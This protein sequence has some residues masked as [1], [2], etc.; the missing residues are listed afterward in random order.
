VRTFTF[1]DDAGLGIYGG[2]RQLAD[3]GPRIPSH[4]ECVR[5]AF[6]PG[7][8]VRL[9]TRPALEPHRC[10]PGPGS[11][12]Y[13]DVAEGEYAS[14]GFAAGPDL[15]YG[16]WE[17]TMAASSAAVVRVCPMLWPKAGE[18]WPPEFN[19]IEMGGDKD[20]AGRQIGNV[21]LHW[22][23]DTGRPPHP[24][25]IRAV[26]ADWTQ[27]HRVRVE[28]TTDLITV[29]LDG[30]E[31]ERFDEHVPDVPMH[32]AAQTAIEG[33]SPADEDI[34]AGWLDLADLQVSRYTP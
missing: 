10:Y 4:V 33:G 16:A 26:H 14:A 19:V 2:A 23:S 22:R 3:Q 15:L 17:W 21:A 25:D 24:Q 28:W 20:H 8:S 30:V 12:P 7:P 34:E 27:P 29:Q 18:G 11:D 9:H 1:E 31:V 5:D 13:Y 6:V 32:F